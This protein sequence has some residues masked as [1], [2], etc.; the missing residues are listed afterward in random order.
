MLELDLWQE[1]TLSKLIKEG[2]P[3]SLFGGEGKLR[4]LLDKKAKAKQVSY[5]LDLKEGALVIDGRPIPLAGIT[6]MAMVKTERLLFTDRDGYFELFTKDGI[7]RPYLMAKQAY[8][9]ETEKEE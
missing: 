8:S 3:Q 7:L 6:D 2:G 9:R 1:E 5:R 4:D